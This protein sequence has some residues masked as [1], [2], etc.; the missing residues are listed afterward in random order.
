MSKEVLY[1][2][3]K[4]ERRGF[5]KT[6]SREEIRSFL[7]AGKPDDMVGVLATLQQFD[8]LIKPGTEDVILDAIRQT[9]YNEVLEMVQ[10]ED[11]VF[12]K[13]S[14]IV[15]LLLAGQSIAWKVAKSWPD[16]VKKIYEG[17]SRKAA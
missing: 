17:F 4:Y 1:N 14:K 10:G 6:F 12:V 15:P 16:G 9:R 13:R 8:Y 2:F 7:R 3:S 5:Y 11:E